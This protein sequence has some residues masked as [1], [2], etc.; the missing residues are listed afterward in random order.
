MSKQ[1]FFSALLPQRFPEEAAAIFAALGKH[2]VPYR[3]L[4]GTKDIW[5]RDFMPVRENGAVRQMVSFRYAPSYLAENPE[6]RTDMKTVA[7][8]LEGPV[9]HFSVIS[10]DGGNMVFVECGNG[11]RVIIS[12]RVFAE[13]PETAPAKLVRRL[14]RQ[15]NMPVIII[16]SLKSDMTGHADGMVRALSKNTVLCN[17]PLSPRGF[18]QQVKTVLEWHGLDTVD[19]PFVP[20]KGISAAGCYLNFLETDEA[21]FLPVFGLEKDAEA[22][23]TAR[24][25][26]TKPVEPVMIP[27]IAAEGGCLNCISWT[28]QTDPFS[29]LIKVTEKS[30]KN[31]RKGMGRLFHA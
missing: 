22:L 27:R 6:L 3:L 5:L 13:N 9:K 23:E 4:E 26:F 11:P 20:A 25:L 10:L 12:D 18:E 14:T 30:K 16:P 21:I 29:N 19:L 7:P 17:R 2:H 8:Q 28:E 24:R 1:V 31:A 15:L